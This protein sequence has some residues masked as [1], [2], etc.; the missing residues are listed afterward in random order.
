L[1]D[2]SREWYGDARKSFE[3]AIQDGLEARGRLWSVQ[4]EAR[5]GCLVRAIVGDNEGD[6]A[7]RAKSYRTHLTVLTAVPTLD[8]L[9]RA[10]TIHP[11]SLQ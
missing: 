5:R 3:H 11:P 10:T 9:G 6:V 8:G 4:R 2:E 1:G 7:V